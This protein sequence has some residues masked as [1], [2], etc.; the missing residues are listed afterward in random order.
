MRLVSMR[1]CILQPTRT[2]RVQWLF[3][4]AVEENRI[5]EW[6]MIKQK[7]EYYATTNKS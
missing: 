5:R 4:L 6:E 2:V 1:G 7:R 3:G